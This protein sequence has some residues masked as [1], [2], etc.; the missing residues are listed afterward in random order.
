MIKGRTR[1]FLCNLSPNSFCLS[2]FTQLILVEIKIK[3]EFCLTVTFD[4]C[5]R[6]IFSRQPPEGGNKK[7]STPKALVILFFSDWL[8]NKTTESASKIPQ[9]KIVKSEFP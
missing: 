9:V 1:Y 7:F 4:D 5:F 8:I 3:D 2:R 6:S